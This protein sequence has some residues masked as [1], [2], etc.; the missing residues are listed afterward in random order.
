MQST[1]RSRPTWV[2]RLV[3]PVFAVAVATVAG[4]WFMPVVVQHLRQQPPAKG[5]AASA[6]AELLPGQTSSFRLAKS[7]VASLGI[8]WRQAEP[9]QRPQQISLSGKLFIDPNRLVSVNARFSGEIVALR[10]HGLN[11]EDRV[12]RAAD[13]WLRFGD[14]VTQGELLAVL[15]SREVGDEKSDLV[16]A[17]SRM[18]LDEQTLARLKSLEPSGAVAER[19]VREAQRN[20]EADLIAANR[21]ERT[22]RSWRFSEEEIGEIKAEAERLHAQPQEQNSE[23]ERRWAEVEIRAPLTGVIVE[24]NAPVGDV[25]D[26]GDV[27]FKIADLHRLGVVVNLYEDQLPQVLRLEAALRRLKVRVANDPTGPEIVVPIERIG[28]VI[29]PNQHTVAVI[30]WIDNP[31]GRLR[32]G[33]FL[34][35]TIDLPPPSD[36]VVLPTTAVIDQGTLG[37]IFVSPARDATVFERRKVVIVHRSADAI[38]IQ[39]NPSEQQRQAGAQPLEPGAWVVSSGVLALSGTL[40]DLDAE[41]TPE[42]RLTG[43]S[44]P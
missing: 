2:V 6:V 39:A 7:T 18:R 42:P 25:V 26:A 43:I 14:S 37:L 19:V 11:T 38:W 12:T 35:A 30:G 23:I 24:H 40:S 13:D 1:L 20:L 36:V 3:L 16:D 28:D 31:E 15:W 22:L 44:P 9:V 8:T 21:A 10:R 17:T 41:A 4:Y 5:P 34:T 29:D 27:L 32:S 33:Q